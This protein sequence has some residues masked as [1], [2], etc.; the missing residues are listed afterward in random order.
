VKDVSLA[1]WMIRQNPVRVDAHAVVVGSVHDLLRE[2][3][4]RTLTN[5]F[6]F[7]NLRT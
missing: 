7:F 3:L 1:K 2:A 6:Q 4:H 5:D